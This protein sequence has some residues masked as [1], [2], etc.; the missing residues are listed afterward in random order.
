MLIAGESWVS[1]TIH[2]KGFDSFTTTE[3]AE[4]VFW[5]RRAL[6]R[7]GYA[8]T[9]L[10]N[11][12]APREFPTTLAD[13]A[14]Y[15]A[16]IL[17]DIGANSLLL[18]PE[19]F[20]RSHA[21]PNRLA[22]LR[23]YVSA[24]GAL[25]M[26]GGYLSFQ[27]IEAKG[28]YRGT[29]VEEVLPVTLEI[30]DDRVE[31]PERPRPSVVVPDHPIVRHLPTR[32]PGLLGYNRLHP[33]LDGAVLVTCGD[34][35]LVAVRECGQGR[36]MAFASDCGPH[37]APLSFVEWDGYDRFWATAMAWLTRDEPP[38]ATTHAPDFASGRMYTG[39]KEAQTRTKV[40]MRA[41]KSAIRTGMTEREVQH[42]AERLTRAA[43]SSGPWCP[44]LV[45]FGENSRHCDP[46]HPPGDRRLQDDDLVMVDLSPVFDGF[47]GD[48]AESFTWG[49]DRYASLVKA[50]R[51]VEQSVL[52]A[53]SQCSSPEDLYSAGRREIEARQLRLLDPL[54]NIGHS[55]GQ[56]AFL[57]GFVEAGNVGPLRGGWTVE[58]FV[59]DG[60]AGAKFEDILFFQDGTAEVL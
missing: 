60:H 18:H 45:A 32:W 11:H 41:L 10:P 3:Y 25:I 52:A 31:L 35:P 17:S 44:T 26:V 8:V 16:I 6:Q 22:L 29:P 49:G 54:Q 27:G 23:T 33:K 43:G 38:A 57:D 58:P 36:T 24:G 56:L 37:W 13:L 39:L 14:R 2:Q 20:V 50:A 42:L 48:F 47:Y 51:E 9:F 53:A 1:H 34:D 7:A 28:A 12:L 40:C 30:G 46:A 59:G 55:I 4:G 5:L 19:T 21:V 15:D